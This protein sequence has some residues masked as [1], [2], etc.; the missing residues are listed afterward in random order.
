MAHYRHLYLWFAHFDSRSSDRIS[1][2]DKEIY[3]SVHVGQKLTAASAGIF[4][5]GSLSQ[6]VLNVGSEYEY[7]CEC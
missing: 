6:D 1:L 2:L 4:S 7:S 3:I 5:V